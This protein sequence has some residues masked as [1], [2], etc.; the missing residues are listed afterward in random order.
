MTL[1]AKEFA[2]SV[3][4]AIKYADSDRAKSMKAAKFSVNRLQYN[5]EEDEYISNEHILSVILRCDWSDLC[6]KFSA[7]FR[8][9]YPYEP[10][11]PIKQRNSEYAIFSR[12]IRESVEIYGHRAVGDYDGDKWVNKTLGPFYCGMSYLMVFPEFNIR[13]CAPTS[14]S[15]QVEVARRFAGREGVI[16][17]VNNNGHSNAG[18][19]RV[20]GCAWLSNYAGEAEYLF[21][22]GQYQIRIENITNVAIKDSYDQFCKVFFCFDCMIKGTIINE[23]IISVKEHYYT[24]I[25]DL[26]QHKL[27]ING[28]TNT[29]PKYINEV[30]EAFTSHQTQIVINLYQIHNH[31]GQLKQ[32]ILR[33][34]M[35][36]L[37]RNVTHII[38]YTTKHDGT[39]PY[40][41]NI[42]EM[43]LSIDLLLQHDTIKLREIIVKAT[44]DDRWK[45][46]TKPSWLFKQYKK[47]KT[48]IKSLTRYDAELIETEDDEGL[49]EDCLVIK[50]TDM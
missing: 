4:K 36:K 12:L 11:S 49:T 9:S 28:F 5:I 27:E 39:E 31:F 6:S 17:Q 30:F 25:N 48:D 38:I 32:L 50:R 29:F 21:A 3:S 46:Q 40:E 14:T 41:L 1:S 24:V 33:N 26:I 34:N 7:T 45:K 43:L 8:S 18:N 23:K 20:F 16:L 35:F 19:L 47:Q 22:G 15:A 10:L 2:I 13:I 42:S 37:F 44:R